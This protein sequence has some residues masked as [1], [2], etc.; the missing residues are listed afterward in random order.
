MVYI[1]DQC[2]LGYSHQDIITLFQAITVGECVTLDVCRGYPL[3]FDPDDPNNEIITT[4]AVTLPSSE[5]STTNPAVF[6]DHVQGRPS[7]ADWVDQGPSRSKSPYIMSKGRSIDDNSE[8]SALTFPGSS[9][10]QPQ[11]GARPELHMV[12]ITRGPMGFGFTIADSIYGQ[13]VKQILDRPRCKILQEGDIL[14]DING[15]NVKDLTH[16]EVVQVLKNCPLGA[17]AVMTVQRGG[18]LL[19][20]HTPYGRAVLNLLRLTEL[21][22]NFVIVCVPPLKIVLLLHC[23]SLSSFI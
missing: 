16:G 8:D 20:A 15:V 13:K 19:Q 18:K 11:G 22:V 2:V 1:N 10:S 5:S 3:P 6:S 12:G 4:V 9:S 21:L 17:E 7:R 23:S 14:V